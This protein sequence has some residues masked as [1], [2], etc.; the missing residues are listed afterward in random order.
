MSSPA[1]VRGGDPRPGSL[2]M[3]QNL[4]TPQSSDPDVVRASY[5]RD[6][7][8][9]LAH[10][11]PLV[12][13]AA[14]Y[15]PRVTAAQQAMTLERGLP[16]AVYELVDELADRLAAPSSYTAI[17]PYLRNNLLVA[18]L[19]GEK[20]LRA[21]NEDDRRSRVRIALE[22]VRQVLRDVSDEAPA[23]ES[24]DTAAV[25][26]FIDDTLSVPQHD[27]AE[28]LGV[29]VRTLQRWLK[30]EAKPEGDDEARVRM[31]AKTLAHLRHMYTAPGVVR[32]FSRPH[33]ALGG[34]PPIA[35]LDDPV[36]ASELVRVAAQS[37]STV[38]S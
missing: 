31:V 32:W 1:F 2:R 16:T 35:L 7:T 28:L 18:L 3:A 22:Q 17:D 26:R 8:A 6:M 15:L 38:A 19:A 33:A 37:R 36:K 9:T 24:A 23:A 20:S 25:V 11:D 30:G 21:A 14:D 12:E 5:T 10:P 29:H 4:A 34:R 13:L 27:I